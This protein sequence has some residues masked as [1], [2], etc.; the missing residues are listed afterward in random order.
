M[1]DNKA[2]IDKCWRRLEDC[3]E[4]WHQAEATYFEP[5]KFRLFLQTFIVTI[6]TVTFLL[7]KEKDGIPDFDNWYEK[8]QNHLKED[9]IMRWM[10]ETRNTIEKQGDLESNSL[11]RVELIASYLEKDYLVLDNDDRC[12]FVSFKQ[13]VEEA[14]EKLKNINFVDEGMFRISRRWVANTYPEEELLNICGYGYKKIFF[15]LHDLSK[16]LGIPLEAKQCE[17]TSLDVPNCMTTQRDIESMSYRVSNLEPIDVRFKSVDLTAKD[18]KRIKRRYKHLLQAEE[19]LRSKKEQSQEDFIRELYEHQ[20]KP[21]FLKDGYH[22]TLIFLLNGTERAGIIKVIFQDKVSKYQI[23][24]KVAQKVAKSGS[25]AIAF[26]S[27]SWQ[28]IYTIPMTQ[29]EKRETLTLMYLNKQGHYFSLD[30]EIIRAGNE[31]SLGS[32]IVLSGLS[33]LSPNILIPI[34][35]IWDLPYQTTDIAGFS[36]NQ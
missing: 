19:A 14:Q 3:H 25:D 26:I 33:G 23:M 4:L 18:K 20:V 32:T 2:I 22:E 11:V 30:S 8:H 6:R 7:Q 1:N 12:L 27:E 5:E 13:L 36:P 24:N 15:I 29:P 16:H 17:K 31:V 34:Y 10:V 28:W 21:I 35:K 9:K